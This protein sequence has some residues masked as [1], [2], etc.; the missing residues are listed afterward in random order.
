MFYAT[1]AAIVAA[2]VC[3]LGLDPVDVP[4]WGHWAAL[5]LL[6]AVLVFVLSAGERFIKAERAS[7]LDEH[8]DNAI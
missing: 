8:R 2:A 3:A 6:F 4:A 5:A 1:I 7:E